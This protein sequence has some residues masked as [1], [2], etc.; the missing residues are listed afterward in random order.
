VAFG[1]VVIYWGIAGT[2]ERGAWRVLA[3]VQALPVALLGG[4]YVLHIRRVLAS[5]AMA[6][7]TRESGWLSS[8][9]VT[10]TGE[11]WASFLE[12]QV[13]HLPPELQARSALLVLGALG[14]SLVS[15]NAVVAVLL[16]GAL[17]VAVLASALGLHPFGLSRH[18][19]WLL[20][21]TLPALGWLAGRV[22]EQG[23]R[24]VY[25]AAG[26]VL[27][28]ALLG[29]P[30]ERQLGAGALETNVARE[31]IFR[32][33][34]LA[35]LVATHLDPAGAPQLILMSLQSYYVLIPFYA[36]E[37]SNAVLSPDS[38]LSAFRYG[39]REVVVVQRWAWET[40]ADVR[41]VLRSLPSRTPRTGPAAAADGSDAREAYEREG[42]GTF[43][44]VAGGWGSGLFRSVPELEEIGALV[45]R[46][47]VWGRDDGGQPT[48]RMAAFVLD[49]RA[50]LGAS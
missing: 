10:S 17:G 29:G 30:I 42:E 16:G 8:W 34:D 12:L 3:T 28:A 26:V 33:E 22:V 49:R 39:E 2:L 37:R 15:R 46:A 21:F 5:E 38:T 41:A 24:A 44:L 19:T 47:A 35:P 9:L 14:A 31:K 48:I 1:A 25:A 45:D 4:L 7:A 23:R 32:A 13:F 27:V 36:R 20:A 40:L 50:L 43:A 6:D 11:A 18:N